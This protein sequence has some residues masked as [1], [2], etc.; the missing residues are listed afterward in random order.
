MFNF[1]SLGYK[2]ILITGGTGSFGKAMVGFIR[3]NSPRSVIRVL[4]RDEDKHRIMRSTFGED[5]IIYIIGDIRDKDKLIRATRGC[6]LIIHGAAMKQIPSGESDPDEHIATNIIGTMNVA[7][8][9]LFHN[10]PRAVFLSTDKSCSPITL[11]GGTKFVAERYWINCNNFAPNTTFVATRYGNVAN[12]RGSVIPLFASLIQRGDRLTVTDMCSTRFFMTLDEATSLVATAIVHGERGDL[13]IPKL[14]AFV[15]S[16]L[17]KAMQELYGD[18]GLDEIGLRR[19]EK[20]HEDLMTR[21]EIKNSMLL[22]ECGAELKSIYAI[23]YNHPHKTSIQRLSYRRPDAYTSNSWDF[24]ERLSVENLNS[25]L[26]D[27]PC[28]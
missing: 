23:N 13:L 26:R 2:E 28:L 6:Q 15:M 4:S 16:D 9:A 8:A 24:V 5:H 14:P 3:E 11:Y 18:T 22:A 10:T 27:I 17:V 12:S 21:D 7:E 20:L 25:L 1:H 19:S